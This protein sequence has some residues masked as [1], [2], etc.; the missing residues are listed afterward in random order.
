MP[1]IATESGTSA[2]RL[3]WVGRALTVPDPHSGLDT[4][5]VSESRADAELRRI[6]VGGLFVGYRQ[7]GSGPPLVLL[8]GAFEDSRFWARQLDD[9]SDEFTVIALDAPGFGAS[10]D[11]S[12]TWTTTDYG[13]HLG[14]ILDALGL[15]RPTVVGLSFGSVY[16]LALYRQRPHAVGALVL[17][18]A[19]AGWAGS[20]SPEEVQR[21]VEQSEREMT[22]PV[23]Q[24][25]GKWL[26]TLLT[27][28]AP[29]D[30]VS[31]VS[32]MMREFHPAGMRPALHALGAVDL[33]DVLGTIAVPTLLVYGDADVRSPA[34]VV[35]EDMR[36]RIPGSTLVVI[37]GAPHLVSLE[38]PE[39]FN[40]AIRQFTRE[41]R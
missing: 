35:G 31:L 37:S 24:I 5:I 39:A 41:V 18:S 29:P 23:D 9:L 1:R 25:V 3:T 17:V 27:P 13:N 22:A 28:A 12:P 40:A 4:R 38:Q 30:V 15:I 33:R 10:D 2:V 26:P 20:L 34:D 36:A 11:P 8:H 21:R 7:A 19:Y 16:A 6:D 14:D 32:A